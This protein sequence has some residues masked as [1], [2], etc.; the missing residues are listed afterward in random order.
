MLDR[1]PMLVVSVVKPL[2]FTVLFK[3]IKDHTW[4]INSDCNPCGKA[5]AR[6]NNLNHEK[7]H[8]AEKPYECIQC[9]EL[10]YFI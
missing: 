8:T 9:G 10:L 6:M 4:E 2:H 3:C 1:N 5:F 7:N